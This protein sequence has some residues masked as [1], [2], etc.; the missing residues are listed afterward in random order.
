MYSKSYILCKHGLSKVILI[1]GII[2]VI[3]VL[4]I[5]LIFTGSIIISII[6]SIGF[7]YNIENAYIKSSKI[8]KNTKE[9]LAR[10]VQENTYILKKFQD[11]YLDCQRKK[12]FFSIGFHSSG[13]KKSVPPSLKIWY[14]L[15]EYL[16]ETFETNEF[17][18][19]YDFFIKLRIID[20]IDWQE[21]FDLRFREIMD[22]IENTES[23]G[24]QIL[25]E[26]FNKNVN[27]SYEKLNNTPFRHK[28][29][30]HWLLSEFEMNISISNNYLNLL[31]DLNIDFEI[32]KT[33]Y[34]KHSQQIDLAEYWLREIKKC[35]INII[36]QFDSEIK[37]LN[38]KIY[39]FKEIE[40]IY[41][42][43]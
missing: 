42:S 6:T 31:M 17:V 7:V 8:K 3:P 38:N 37:L 27:E 32:I 25:K 26:V 23:L 14:E 12:I 13:I 2:I 28:H 5:N 21:E 1:V 36:E 10:E 29:E 30:I 20:N 40:N 34:E 24:E 43:R 16:P 15:S 9:V 39:E 4:F 11:D 35:D 41:V 33:I 18:K 22:L 19:L